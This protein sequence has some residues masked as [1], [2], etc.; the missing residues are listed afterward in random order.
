M[1]SSVYPVVSKINGQ[2]GENLV[3]KSGLSNGLEQ[4]GLNT[5]RPTFWVYG[6]SPIRIGNPAPAQV[7]EV[8]FDLLPYPG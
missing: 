1:K 8:V 2:Q 5:N 4:R 6:T 3:T 7:T